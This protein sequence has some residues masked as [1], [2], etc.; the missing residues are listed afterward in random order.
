M[1]APF[2]LANRFDILTWRQPH[3]LSNILSYFSGTGI[4]P[5]RVNTVAHNDGTL[6]VTVVVKQLAEDKARAI[7]ENLKKDTQVLRT[8]LEHFVG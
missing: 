2:E 8:M 1:T 5:S 6:S 4:D 7:H 3:A